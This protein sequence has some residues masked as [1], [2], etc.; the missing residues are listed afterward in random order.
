MTVVICHKN[1]FTLFA[2]DVNFQVYIEPGCDSI[3]PDKN[4][5]KTVETL[6]HN[7]NLCALCIYFSKKKMIKNTEMLIDR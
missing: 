1:V 7:C 5:I 6:G 3:I 4:T 2:N